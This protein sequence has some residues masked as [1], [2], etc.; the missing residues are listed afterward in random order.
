MYV[1]LIGDILCK[2]E[3]LIF[4][5]PFERKAFQIFGEDAKV[6]KRVVPLFTGTLTVSRIAQILDLDVQMLYEV[7]RLLESHKIVT[8]K[9][10]VN[11]KI[12]LTTQSLPDSVLEAIQLQEELVDVC[13]IK[14]PHQISET[15]DLIVAIDFDSNYDFF[16]GIQ[17]KSFHHKTPWFKVSLQEPHLL[18]G[19]F[20]FPDGGPCYTCSRTRIQTNTKFNSASEMFGG[21]GQIEKLIYPF[22]VREL[23]KFIKT[24]ARITL[25]EREAVINLSQYEVDTYR[26][27]RIP[28]CPSC[29]EQEASV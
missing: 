13:Q 7:T 8:L 14:S 9:E 22:V 2:G 17:K 29:Q 3:D 26:V 5:D 6:L 23:L 25:F 15:D 16:H 11:S 4:I 28:N 12:V 10:K 21:Y 18:L 24:N 19:P 20:F 1:E 27:L